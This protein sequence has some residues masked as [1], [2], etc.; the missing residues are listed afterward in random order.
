MGT[1]EKTKL[2]FSRS[3][4][5]PLSKCHLQKRLVSWSGVECRTSFNKAKTQVLCRFMSCS[6]CAGDTRRWES[7][8]MVAAGSRKNTFRWSAIP[9]KQSALSHALAVLGCLPKSRR[10]LRLVFID[11]VLLFWRYQCFKFLFSQLMTS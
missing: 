2:T 7:L 1:K 4:Y 3:F 6:K 11:D 5:N 10:D 8:T 9:Q